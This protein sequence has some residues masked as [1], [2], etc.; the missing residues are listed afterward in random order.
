MKIQVNQNDGVNFVALTESGHE[1]AMDGGAEVGGQNQG[2]RPMEVVLA[3]LGGCSA[4]D[5]MLIL[6]KS[7]QHVSH[8]EIV[9]TAE[10]ADAIPAVF[11]KIHLLYRV[12][13]KQLDRAKV[14]RAISLSMEKY[15][16]VTKMLEK[17]A[18]MSFAFEIIEA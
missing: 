10:R 15:C 16:S 13:G 17:T 12:S 7:R 14:A 6:N 2:A 5:V 18:A 9:I 1:I 8:C 11:T 3:G 4:I